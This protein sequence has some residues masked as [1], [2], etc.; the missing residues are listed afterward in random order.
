MEDPRFNSGHDYTKA[1]GG[2]LAR[3]G[4]S[5]SF[6]PKE[7]VFKVDRCLSKK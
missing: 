6:G 2:F 4:C 3:V 7:S 5:P 1:S